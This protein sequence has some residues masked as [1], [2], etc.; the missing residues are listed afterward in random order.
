MAVF[1]YSLEL[2]PF[3]DAE[4]YAGILLERKTDGARTEV[5]KPQPTMASLTRLRQLLPINQSWG[6]CEEYVS[7]LEVWNSAVRGRDVD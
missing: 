6:P 1:Q 3:G 7:S 2:L 5:W 4:K